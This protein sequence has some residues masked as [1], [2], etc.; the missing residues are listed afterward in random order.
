MLI[1]GES[2]VCV[3]S[4]LEVDDAS[5]IVYLDRSIDQEQNKRILA[6]RRLS[7]ETTLDKVRIL[8]AADQIEL[9]SSKATRPSRSRSRPP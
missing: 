6:S 1:Q 9:P 2:D 8:F 3:T 4:I 7:F 5:N